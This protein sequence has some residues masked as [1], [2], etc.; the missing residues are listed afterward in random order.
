MRPWSS[1]HGSVETH[2]T[3]IHEDAGSIPGLAQWVK[4]LALLWLWCRPAAAAPIQPQPGNLHIPACPPKIKKTQKNPAWD[5]KNC[6]QKPL[7]LSSLIYIQ[8]P[9]YKRQS[10]ERISLK[11]HRG[12]NFRVMDQAVTDLQLDR[13]CLCTSGSSRS[14]ILVL[15][16]LFYSEALV[17]IGCDSV[18][19]SFLALGT[20]EYSFGKHISNLRKKNKGSINRRQTFISL[21]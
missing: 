17:V 9:S 13:S 18:S 11:S 8:S 12:D 4:D 19:W 14:L 7:H 10:W 20:L 3:S 15:E 1:C 21:P 5:P 16:S 6:G 2:L